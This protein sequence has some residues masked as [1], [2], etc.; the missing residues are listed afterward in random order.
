MKKILAAIS[1]S[2]CIFSSFVNCAN[3]QTNQRQEYQKAIT[4]LFHT[5]SECKVVYDLKS[6]VSKQADEKERYHFNS[7]YFR[8]ILW[9]LGK[10]L[11]YTK[12]DID[13]E[14]AKNYSFYK[15]MLKNNNFD[16]EIL[17]NTFKSC[18]ILH[19]DPAGTIV[20]KLKKAGISMATIHEVMSQ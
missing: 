4:L 18:Q 19:F 11:H 7:I 13:N 2:S 6:S 17:S 5:Y 10:Q 3:S 1:I 20:E 9:V 8:N 14:I 15:D 12:S 16:H